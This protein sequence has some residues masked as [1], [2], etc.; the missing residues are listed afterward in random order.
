[1]ELKIEKWIYGGDGLARMAPDETGRGKAVFVP[2]V[3]P[4]ETVQAE[5]TEERSGFARAKLTEMNKASAGRVEPQCPYFYR[6]GGCQYQHADYARQLEWKRDILVETLQRTAKIK[7]EHVEI[8]SAEPYQY[9]NRT[10]LKTRNEPG[11]AIGYHRLGTNELLPVSDCPIS[12]PLIR[13]A[14]A[15]T[16]KV[17]DTHNSGGLREI[18]FF[19]NHADSKLLVEFYTDRDTSPQVL[20]AFGDALR[21]ELP[22]ILGIVI[23]PSTALIEDEDRVLSA[24]SKRAATGVAFG[25]SSLQYVTAGG[26]FRVSAGSFFQTN[27]FL[28]DELVKTALGDSRGATALDLYAGTGLFS[29]PVARR[30]DRVIAV[31]ASPFS[32]AD[33]VNNVS[34]NVKPVQATTEKYL[35]N[36]GRRSGLHLVLVDPPRSGM[37]EHTAQMLGRTGVP[38]ITYVSCDP[39]TLARDLRVLSGAGYR[40]ESAHLVDLFPQTFHMET[41][42]QLV[43]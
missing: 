21:A 38:H 30:F 14:I 12:S 9:R 42:V 36:T 40:I 10:R 5:I 24:S 16:W 41:V 37:G 39:A 2:F 4:G 17:G 19:A 8:H 20:Q 29:V 25:E 33:L 18:Q 1:M 7:L 26:S 43:R 6:C 23:F 3:V 32:F 11:F 28:I 35:E 31:E 13:R 34:A 15:A 22:A 27:R